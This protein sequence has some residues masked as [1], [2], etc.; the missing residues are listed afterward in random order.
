MA[1]RVESIKATAL[2][3]DIHRIVDYGWNLYRN[4]LP[5]GLGAVS[6]NRASPSGNGSSP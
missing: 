2:G 6:R 3:L 5:I 4:D 1:S